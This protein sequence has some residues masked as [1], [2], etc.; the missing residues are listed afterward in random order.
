MIRRTGQVLPVL[1]KLRWH[2]TLFLLN[3]WVYKTHYQDNLVKFDLKPQL[4]GRLAPTGPRNSD[5][6]NFALQMSCSRFKTSFPVA[7][8]YGPV[9]FRSATRLTMVLFSFDLD[10]S[11]NLLRKC[12]LLFKF[13]FLRWVLDCWDCGCSI[14]LIAIVIVVDTV[15]CT[16]FYEVCVYDVTIYSFY[17]LAFLPFWLENIVKMRLFFQLHDIVSHM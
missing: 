1:E 10:F 6:E 12:G 8:G 15:S 4:H 3:K 7:G 5:S 2:T 13:F 9:R 17:G 14:C 16:C 11:A